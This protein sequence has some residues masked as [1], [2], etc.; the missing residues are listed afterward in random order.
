[1]QDLGSNLTEKTTKDIRK[2]L[3][4][5]SVLLA[6]LEKQLSEL[7]ESQHRQLTNSLSGDLDEA[8]EVDELPEFLQVPTKEEFNRFTLPYY[9]DRESDKHQHGRKSFSKAKTRVIGAEMEIK[10]IRK[11]DKPEA[12]EKQTLKSVKIHDVGVGVEALDNHDGNDDPLIVVI[13]SLAI[14]IVAGILV[15]V[16]SAYCCKRCQYQRPLGSTRPGPAYAS[17][18][19]E[20]EEDVYLEDFGEGEFFEWPKT[21]LRASQQQDQ[22]QQQQQQQLRHQLRQKQVIVEYTRG[23]SEGYCRLTTGAE[24]TQL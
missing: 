18:D 13:I 5:S 12:E 2:M 16:L 7:K 3:S 20:N 4:S 23:Y 9:F 1:M 6:K 14:V 8:D 11:K 24:M 10:P 22:P 21:P 15:A 17:D 19:F